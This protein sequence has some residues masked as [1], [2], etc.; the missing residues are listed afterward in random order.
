MQITHPHL[1]FV[2]VVGE[3][4]GHALGQRGD[5][6]PLCL[7][8]AQ[9]D[10]RQQVVDLGRGG[11]NDEY[12][13]D[14]PGRTDELLDNLSL[15]CRFVVGRGGRNEDRLPHQGFELGELQ[16]PVVECRRQTE[17]VIDEVLLARA[18]ALVHAADLRNRDMGLVDE[19]QR[20]GSQIVDQG[21]RGFTGLASREMPG[22][23]LDP[24]AETDLIEHFEVETG[25][26]LD[27][28]RLDQAIFG[29]EE[30]NP[31]KEFALDRLDRPQHRFAR[32]DVVRR[33]ENR[34]AQQPGLQMT[35]QGVEKLQA[36]DLVVEQRDPDRLFGVFS[37]EYVD[38]V[39]ANAK[40]AA[41]K[42]GLIALVLHVGKAFDQLALTDAIA[43]AH[44]QD[45]LA[46]L[47]AVTEAINARDG[48]ND[49]A[50]TAFEQALGGGQAHLLDVLVDRRILFDEQVAC[51]N[52]SLGLVVVVIGN[53]IL[54]RVVGKELAE[55]GIE[56]CSERLVGCQHQ[57]R[58]AGS[59]DDVGHGVGLARAGDAEQGLEREP[60][61]Q[62]LD[63]LVNCRRLIT[64]RQ[65]GLVETKRAAL[66]G[67]EGR[68][69]RR[70]CS[71]WHARILR[72][73]A[74]DR[75]RERKRQSGNLSRG[76]DCASGE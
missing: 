49:H 46:V 58:T 71:I 50:I 73:F 2:E 22:I 9:S 69:L 75:R 6:H 26:L 5:Q 45:H 66:E 37:G 16:R 13:V 17:S 64:S 32:G 53:K 7:C 55:F 30:S 12:R 29:V 15:M 48:G 36:F 11:A 47:V 38:G 72:C 42:V 10:L 19:H 67:D 59:R 18:V 41:V 52:I 65:E 43:D 33:W 1:V 24:L 70:T 54:D 56:L 51:R 74:T 27:A 21:G 44:D 28:L 3:I 63:Q 8:D 23:V 35:G 40:G 68:L 39:A 76:P 62:S 14:Q 57:R 34:E 61:L 31:L 4:F 60:I 20:I 25:A